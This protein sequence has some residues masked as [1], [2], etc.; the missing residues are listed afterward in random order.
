MLFRQRKKESFRERLWVHLW[1]R[2]SFSRSLK[3]YY[4]RIVRL[5]ATP[6]AIG[7]GLAA[8]TFASFFPFGLHFVMAFVLA[9]L[10]AGNLVAAALGTA[11]GNP[12]T[13]P[14]MWTAS[15]QLGK[16]ILGGGTAGHHIQ[17]SVASMLEHMDF[18]QLWE[19]VLK[20]IAVGALPLGLVVALASYLIA[21]SAAATFQRTRRERL[22][23]GGGH[24]VA[25]TTGGSHA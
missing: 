5:A 24:A 13:F 10:L 23:R 4:K 1:P 18:G 16:A 11:L 6:H 14:V 17:G 7:M 19:P 25:G 22:A 8:G 21:R 15:Y 12:V 2:R 20:P 9:W 3:Y